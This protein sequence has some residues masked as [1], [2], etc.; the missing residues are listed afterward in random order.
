MNRA[1]WIRRGEL[2][3]LAAIFA[4]PFAAQA[5]RGET[6]RCAFD[7]AAVLDTFRVR[8][9]DADGTRHAFCGVRCAQAWIDR[10]GGAPPQSIL[11]T[12]CRTGEAIDAMTATYLFAPPARG[13]TVPDPI[14]VFSS[15]ADAHRHADAH[16]G[17]VLDESEH[18]FRRPHGP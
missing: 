14:R 9:V 17:S 13:E 6:E 15:S 16:G 3:A 5:L 10:S 2:L 12:D 8:I 7:G 11:V 1:G 4:L 18:P